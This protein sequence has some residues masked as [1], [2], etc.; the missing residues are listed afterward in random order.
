MSS[1]VR[2]GVSRS[3][4]GKSTGKDEI[5]SA[6]DDLG[7]FSYL[8]G[9]PFELDRSIQSA[10]ETARIHIAKADA[11]ISRPLPLSLTQAS[12]DDML[13][14]DIGRVEKQVRLR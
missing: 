11:L 14:A 5:D 12:N 13:L 1:A 6:L 9:V 8:D 2:G 10:L 7:G 3:Y 4:S